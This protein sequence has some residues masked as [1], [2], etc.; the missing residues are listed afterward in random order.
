MQKAYLLL[1]NNQQTGPYSREEILQLQLRPFDL[2]WVEGES[3]AWQYPGEIKSLQDEIPSTL[4]TGSPSVT[5]KPKDGVTSSADYPQESSRQAKVF[6]SLPGKPKTFGYQQK[7]MNVPD[8]TNQP[9]QPDQL[10][11][12][13][14]HYNPYTGA[15]SP[16]TAKSFNHVKMEEEEIPSWKYSQ[17]PKKKA[18]LY[19]KSIVFALILIVLV[20]GS[21]YLI[22]NSSSKKVIAN[23]TIP[24]APSIAGTVVSTQ[25]AEGELKAET[26][27]PA[28][29]TLAKKTVGKKNVDMTRKT[30][31]VV[32]VPEKN[33]PV[34]PI[35][36]EAD[37]AKDEV[38]E[39]IIL[40]P[41]TSEPTKKEKKKLG[42][43]VRN[44]FGKKEKKNEE[45]EV[46]QVNEDPRPAINRQA[47]RRGESSGPGVLPGSSE[48]AEH[49]EISSNAPENWMM[50]IQDLKV[51]LRNRNEFAIRKATVDVLY[52]DRD[53]KMIDK[54]TLVFSNVA[55]R[56]K[57]VVSAPDHKWADHVEFRLGAVELK[58]D[59]Y[60]KD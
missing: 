4:Q 2:V 21:F 11:S 5:A 50:G 34:P 13:S 53:N 46:P 15:S 35:S 47:Q 56:N 31:S 49:I 28:T 41:K 60:A 40:A 8:A 16:Y 3:A 55:A 10:N 58:D 30:S 24:L 22:G 29:T 44:I 39:E 45:A 17:A 20:V 38:K 19:R 9:D 37:P 52:L 48:L 23:Q 32:S 7:I 27:R 43:V 54:K 36:K 14:S 57:L 6:V 1:R 26:E 18:A 51:T 25:T 12:V 42:E 33:E 59:R